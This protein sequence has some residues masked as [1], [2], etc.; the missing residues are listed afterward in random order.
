MVVIG[1]VALAVCILSFVALAIGCR[2]LRKWHRHGERLIKEDKG[3]PPPELMHL[4]LDRDQPD[5]HHTVSMDVFVLGLCS[6][7]IAFW[8]F[9]IHYT[10]AG[11]DRRP[12]NSMPGSEPAARDPD[13]VPAEAARQR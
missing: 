13:S 2:I 6:V 10:P 12:E 8:I 1:K 7:F 4:H 11:L 5:W 3:R 9:A